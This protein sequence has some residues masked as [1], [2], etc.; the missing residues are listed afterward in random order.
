MTRQ[1]IEF[2]DTSHVANHAFHIWTDA[3]RH[4]PLNWAY[5]YQF[6]LPDVVQ[7]SNDDK[8][9]IVAILTCILRFNFDN[10]VAWSIITSGT[11][12]YWA[13]ANPK[14]D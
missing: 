13:N 10:I 5:I 6:Q 11:L 12:K 7:A 2:Q 1:N 4:Q 14:Y 9:K 8:N 3:T